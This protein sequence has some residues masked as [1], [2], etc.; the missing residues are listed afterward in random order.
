MEESTQRQQEVSEHKTGRGTRL[1]HTWT[2]QHIHAQSQLLSQSI[3]VTARLSMTGPE[4]WVHAMAT[5]KPNRIDATV[6]P[7]NMWECLPYTPFLLVMGADS[8]TRPPWSQTRAVLSVPAA[9]PC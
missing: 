5:L 1:A 9:F 8:I 3:T 2:H 6:V 7:V 4:L